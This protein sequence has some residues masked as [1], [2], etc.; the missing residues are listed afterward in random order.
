MMLAVCFWIFALFFAL[1]K[2]K[3]A[4]WLSGFHGLPEEERAKYDR[5]RMAEDARNQFLLWGLVMLAG[6][7]TAQCI[8]GWGAAAAFVVWLVLFFMNVHLDV[9]KAYGKYKL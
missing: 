8:S 2:D 7:G 6:A 1:G 5:K 4:D 9:D 3:A